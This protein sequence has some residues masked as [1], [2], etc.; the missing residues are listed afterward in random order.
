MVRST[1][2]QRE[3]STEVV[4]LLAMWTIDHGARF[5]LNTSPVGGVPQA[6]LRDVDPLIVP[7]HERRRPLGFGASQ[8]AHCRVILRNANR[9]DKEV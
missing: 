1:L 2:V 3:V 4:G 8:G 6:L 5:I 9:F 7:L